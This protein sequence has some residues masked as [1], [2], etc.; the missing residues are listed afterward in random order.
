L[1][2]VIKKWADD[3]IKKMGLPAFMNNVCDITDEQKLKKLLYYAQK[4]LLCYEDT[5]DWFNKDDKN[6]N[7]D[8]L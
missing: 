4:R 7:I 5:E 3:D 6:K 1:F 2:S 8:I